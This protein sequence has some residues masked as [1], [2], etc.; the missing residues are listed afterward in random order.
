MLLQG[1]VP[2]FAAV[3]VAQVVWGTGSTFLSGADQA[4]LADEI[5]EDAVGPVFTRET[6]LALALTVVATLVAGGLGLLG[7][8][9]PVAASGTGLLV[10]A[11]VLLLV[12]PEEHFHG[13]PA[14]E[15]DTFRHLLGTA[16][17]GLRV[18]RRRPVVRTIALVALV[19]GLASEAFDR[20]WTV[21]V[22]ESFTLPDVAGFD[23][24]VVWFT[25]IALTGTL[26]SLVVSLVVNRVA[27]RWSASRWSS[28]WR[29]P[30]AAASGSC[31]PRCGD[32]ARPGRWRRR[33]ARRG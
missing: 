24:A 27:P 8:G 2:T 15:R 10:L 23:G 6:Q 19:V 29:S 9:V 16:R 25:A 22:L 12:M 17:E 28:S 30:S 4:W 5:G 26:V 18:A 7:L 14:A 1:L 11:V 21:R 31:S 20:L 33:S 13:T 32:A 3:L